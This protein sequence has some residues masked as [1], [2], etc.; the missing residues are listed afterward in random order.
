MKKRVGMS[1]LIAAILCLVFAPGAWAK[2]H[3][4]NEWGFKIEVPDNWQ[5]RKFMHDSDRVNAFVTPDQM[6]AVRV[7]AFHT[8]PGT[9][10]V[11]VAGL[12]EQHVITGAERIDYKPLTV[13]GLAGQFAAYKWTFNNT[14][15]GVIAFYAARGNIGYVVWMMTPSDQFQTRHL[16]GTNVMDTFTL[17]PTGGGM[18]GSLDAGPRITKIATGDQMA[19]DYKLAA[20]KTQFGPTT[21]Y[22]HMVFEYEGEASGP[23]LLIKWIYVPKNYLIDEVKLEMPKGSGGYGHS[24]L[25]KPNNNWPAGE[26]SVQI[27]RNN[28]MMKEARFN[29]VGQ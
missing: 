24:D 25:S 28:Q 8:Q 20:A 3:Q 22:F 18:G 16:E 7:R 23:P 12:F 14:P 26:Y 27:W 15:V 17:V 4:D 9:T 13:N 1:L 10:A 11:Q 21:P 6:V 29:V 5:E 19:G 2:W